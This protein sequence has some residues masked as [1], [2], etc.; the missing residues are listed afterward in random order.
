MT[1]NTLI[2]APVM[3]MNTLIGNRA[4]ERRPFRRTRGLIAL[5]LLCPAGLQAFDFE[6]VT[7]AAGIAHFYEQDPSNLESDMEHPVMTGGAVAED[8][9]GD[10]WV[11]LFVLQGG[12]TANLLYMNRGDGTF[13]D[14]A[15]ARGVDQIGRFTGACGADYDSD[16]DI[17]LFVSG[18]LGSHL[19]LTNDGSGHFSVDA[20]Q[21]PMPG[22]R[23]SSPSW[24]DIDG[25][26]LLDLALGAWESGDAGSIHIYRNEGGGRFAGF[27][28]IPVDWQYTPHFADLDD[29]GHVDLV[30][31][32][33]FG[34]TKWY[35]NDGRG[36]LLP[37]GSSDVENGMGIASGDPDNDGDLDL[38]ITAIRHPTEDTSAMAGTSGNR[39]LLNEGDGHFVDATSDAGVRVG[40]WGWGA[41]FGDWE[42]DGDEDLFEVNGWPAF[43]LPEPFDDTPALLFENQGSAVFQEVAS[44]SG[45]AADRGQGRCVVSFDYDNDGDLDLFIVNNVELEPVRGEPL[46]AVSPGR[47]VLLRNDSAGMGNWLKVTVSGT[48]PHHAHG[49]GARVLATAAGETMLREIHASSN[50]NGHGP[51]RIAHFGAGAAATFDEVRVVFPNRDEVWLEDV[52]VNRR[53]AIDS[54]RAIAVERRLEAGDA[55]ELR[56]PAVAVPTGA[57]VVWMHG[58]VEHADPATIRFD[59]PGRHDVEARIYADASKSRLLRGESYRF[60]VIDPGVEGPSIAR[61]WNE[62]ILEAIR[63]DFPNP[64]VHARNLFHLSVAMWD[65]WA[66][67]DPEAAGYIHRESATAGDIAAAR[68]EAVSYAAYRVLVA[69]YAKSVDPATSRLLFDLKMDE[70]G[71]P[72]ALEGTAGDT[73]SALGNRVA[74]AVLEWGGSD[75]SRE[76]RFY[77]D[78]GYEPVNEPLVLAESGTVLDDPNR[79][80]PLRFR[81]AL[82]QNGLVTTTTQIF[83]GSHWGRVRPF[84]LEGD[85]PIYLDPG[86]PPQLDGAGDADFRHGSL[87]VVR[88]SS[89]LDPD[90]G[91][92]I[93]ISPRSKGLN[94]LGLNDGAGHGAAPN[95]ATGQPYEPQWVKRADYGRVIAEF[96]ADGPDSETPPGHWNSLAN[97][98][99]DHPSMERKYRGEG[100]VMGRLEWD[101]KLYFMLNGALHDA[102]VAAW[103]CKRTYDYVR[104]IS[105]IR[106]LSATGGLPETP[107]LVER[108]TAESSAPGERHA[109]LVAAGASIGDTAIHAWA[110]EPENP[111]TEYTG[112]RWILGA[113]WLPYQRDTFVTP[114]FAGYVSGHSAFSRAAAE[115]LTH[116]TG[117]GYFPGGL[118]THHV[119]AGSLEFEYGPVTDVTLEWATYYDAGDEAG[120]SRLYGGI[121][122]PADDGPGRV[123]G[124]RAGRRAAWLAERY[125]D[126]SIRAVGPRAVVESRDGGLRLRMNLVRGFYYKL[127]SSANLS[128]WYDETNFQRVLDDSIV[129]PLGEAAPRKFF[130]GVLSESP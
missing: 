105:A 103:G 23:S 92:M 116:F 124:A 35:L 113:D 38:F 3:T 94:Q 51:Y 20:S 111:A 102:A 10:G 75:G 67:Y 65:A 104:P 42:N 57:E 84:A 73:P 22:T 29:D 24:A 101:V 128:E 26:G 37:A 115:V 30:A 107:G 41:V 40:Y 99:S 15:A 69:R 63:L 129:I 59:I 27:Q 7:R 78:P 66:A 17:D 120:I 49:M 125:F 72:P 93:D 90:D 76:D 32:A 2:T 81:E 4:L 77:D 98:A 9:D 79:W 109:Q 121:H 88:F 45:D 127:Q 83:V 130:R 112:K 28:V 11:D 114:A 58:G 44:N 31:V 126:G 106:H 18:A 117:D 86:P 74:A 34:N 122:V 46:P 36:V 118:G 50:F 100:E 96:W 95:P 82:T 68:R 48:A 47:P 25:D 52:G 85:P 13:V 54:P 56:M 39:L 8:F 71:Y 123:M 1:T 6:D 60:E 53:I 55:V 87:E 64:A 33:D 5:G 19:L 70:L 21:F 61:V 110:G 108:I 12:L 80:Q 119:P 89:W 91:V 16:G 43:A 62:L 14:E 97:Q